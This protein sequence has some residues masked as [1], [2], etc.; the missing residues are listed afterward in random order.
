MSLDDIAFVQFTS[1]S[2][3]APKGVARHASQPGGEHRGDQR[4]RRSRL[5]P[6]RLGGELAAAVP[7]HGTGRHGA[8]GDVLRPAGGADGAA[9]VREEAGRLAASDLASSRHGQLRAQFR[10]RPVRAPGHGARS[11]RAGSVLLA[12]GG[13]RRRTD[14]CAVARRVC[15]EASR[16]RISG[17][18]LSPQLRSRRARAGGDVRAARPAAARRAPVGRRAGDACRG[19]SERRPDRRRQ[20]RELRSG[21]A[22]PPDPHRRRERGRGARPRRWARSRWRD[23]R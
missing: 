14:S 18:Q 16:R 21:L 9:G 11:R 15:R 6:D 8:G 3:S 12:R 13:M 5:V 7:R 4:T 2:T 20:R 19:D 17:D 23:R 22:G 1:G 10:L